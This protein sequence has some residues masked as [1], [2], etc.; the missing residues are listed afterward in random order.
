MRKSSRRGAL[1]LAV[2]AL[3]VP[4]TLGLASMTAQSAPLCTPKTGCESPDTS[5]PGTDTRP[6]TPIKPGTPTETPTDPA[7]PGPSESPTP[8]DEPTDP[9]TPD[10]TESGIPTKE[11]T[12]EPTEPVEATKDDDA[13]MFTETPAAL[14]SESLSFKG[15][16]GI[17]I[18]SVPTADGGSTRALKISADEIS[19]AGFSLTVSPPYEP[20]GGGLL[21]T[22][23]TMTLKGDV[24]VYIGS[25]TA[26][27]K[28]G[29][30]LTIG[31]DTPPTLDD[32]KPGL[33]RVTMG[34]VGATAGSIEYSNTDQEIVEP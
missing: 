7:A 16:S 22:A 31:T 27:T 13:P 2:L 29:S 32:V 9:A 10:P 19:I 26:T 5:G 4:S 6:S 25:I 17:A 33:L 20:E 1:L 11:P 8:S 15:L 28:D 3:S 23:D 14:G 24:E 30:S 12:E 18:V 34:L 21:T